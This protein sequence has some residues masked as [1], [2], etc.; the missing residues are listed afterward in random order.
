LRSRGRHIRRQQ[1]RALERDHVG[2]AVEDVG[3]HAAGYAF[4]ED[5]GGGRR[6]VGARV[7]QLDA[8]I[9]LLECR[10]QRTDRLVHDQRRVP[11][12]LAFLPCGLDQG[13]VGAIGILARRENGQR[14]QN[15]EGRAHGYFPSG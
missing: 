1:P 6:L 9:L 14:E 5:L 15:D 10:L 4:L 2:D 7:L 12:D 11:D 8:G 13:S 3:L